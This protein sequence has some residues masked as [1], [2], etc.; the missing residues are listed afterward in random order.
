[1]KITGHKCGAV[2]KRYAINNGEGRTAALAEIDAY[3]AKTIEAC[4]G[5]MTVPEMF[6]MHC[7][8]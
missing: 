8:N 3:R 1:M 6:A 4:S 2:Y 7:A 5:Q